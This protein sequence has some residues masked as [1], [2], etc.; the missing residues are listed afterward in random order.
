VTTPDEHQDHP[1]NLLERVEAAFSQ[2]VEQAARHPKTKE[3][4]S[5][6]DQWRKQWKKYP[7]SAVL[8]I[9]SGFKPDPKLTSQLISGRI[10]IRI[11]L[12]KT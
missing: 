3:L 11:L 10:R 5:R 6:C 4:A 2:D 1:D 7:L 8:R 12:S 9:R